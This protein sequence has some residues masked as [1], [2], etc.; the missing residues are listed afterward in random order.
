MLHNCQTQT[1]PAG[2]TGTRW[3]N[4]IEPLEDSALFTIWDANSLVSDIDFN[5]A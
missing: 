4:S 2:L 3:I 1:R 5:D